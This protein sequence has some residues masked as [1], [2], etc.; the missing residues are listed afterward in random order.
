MGCL[1]TKESGPTINICLKMLQIYQSLQM[2]LLKNYLQV[3]KTKL[4]CSVKIIL[5]LHMALNEIN[6]VHNSLGT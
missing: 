1:P 3:K 2:E 4:R 6:N 5:Y